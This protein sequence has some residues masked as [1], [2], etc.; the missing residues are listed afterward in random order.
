MPIN[1]NVNDLALSGAR[2]EKPIRSHQGG[3]RSGLPC[4]HAAGCLR[5]SAKAC[6]RDTSPGLF[7]VA[8]FCSNESAML[9]NFARVFLLMCDLSAFCI[10][11]C[12]STT[13]SAGKASERV[14]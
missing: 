3:A 9:F 5:I 11:F 12:R 8:A 14:N 10:A 1:G 7:A 4:D 13:R 6:N 2:A